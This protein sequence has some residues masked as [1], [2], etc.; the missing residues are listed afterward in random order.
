M[1][2]GFMSFRAPLA[3]LKQK[4]RHN[5]PNMQQIETQFQKLLKFMKRHLLHIVSKYFSILCLCCRYA[6]FFAFFIFI[7]FSASYAFHLCVEYD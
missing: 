6:A 2:L 4:N 5:C 3:A 1:C 7:K